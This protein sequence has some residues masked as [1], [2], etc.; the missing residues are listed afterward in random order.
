[1]IAV[2]AALVKRSYKKATFMWL[3]KR[4][5]G[6]LLIRV[7]P[8]PIPEVV[9]GCGSTKKIGDIIRKRGCKKPLVVTDAMLVKHGLVQGCLDSVREAGCD[10][11]IFDNVVANPPSEV[12]EEGFEIY[13]SKGCDSIIA[14]G[15]GSPMD[16]AKI[17]GAKISNPR[18]IAWYE[19]FFK[20]TLGGLRPLP[21]FFA[22]PTTAGTGSETT[23]AAIITLK[24][25]QRKIVIADLGL[26]PAVAI[27]DPEILEKL[28]KP[29]TA[30]TGID[31]LTHA[32]ES[33]LNGWSSSFTR[34][35]ALSAVKK[36]FK[37]LTKSY[38]NGSDM[39]ARKDMLEASFEAGISFTRANV[40]YVHG[41]AHQFGAMYHTPH[42]DVNAMILPY[43]LDHYLGDGESSTYCATMY[44][45]LAVAG[46]MAEKVP[47]DGDG[48]R[49][50]AE[51]FVKQIRQMSSQMN[52]PTEVKGL[53]AADVKEVARRAFNESH[54]EVHSVLSNPLGYALDLGFPVPVY[55]NQA[56]LESIIANV[57]P[58]NEKASWAAGKSG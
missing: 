34:T 32:V 33:Y 19:G 44:C 27:L 28:P 51:A 25:E 10:C 15:G 24:A 42:G 7:L 13:K 55:M 35:Y 53:C 41:I 40:G 3:A 1:M 23:V 18:P 8:V 16:T 22:V 47:A 48:Q 50:L 45:E 57:L 31:A 49:K 38:E 9:S 2:A 29:V 21:P 17:V 26:V 56:D 52:I 14:F 46:G 54:G 11:E 58:E 30:A 36:I 20:A 43:V 4:L 5:L 12:V 37:S 6:F 39:D